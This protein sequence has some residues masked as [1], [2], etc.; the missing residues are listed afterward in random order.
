L[1]NKRPRPH[2]WRRKKIGQEWTPESIVSEAELLNRVILTKAL[3]A[4]A[5]NQTMS[6]KTEKED[7]K[8][9]PRVARDVMRASG[10]YPIQR[11][12]KKRRTGK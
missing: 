8:I 10:Q 3:M 1:A 7:L 12:R 4:Y 5:S 6:F 2:I 11:S 9:T